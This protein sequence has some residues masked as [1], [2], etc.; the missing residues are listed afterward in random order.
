MQFW[1]R[2]MCFALLYNNAYAYIRRDGMG[3]PV[4]LIPLLPDRTCKEWHH[5]TRQWVYTTEITHSET[6]YDLRTLFPSQ[7][8]HLQGPSID[9]WD[10]D[11]RRGEFLFYAREALG[12]AI[13]QRH[14]KAHYFRRGGRV[15]GILTLPHG[16]SKKAADSLEEGFRRTYESVENSFKTFVA[17]DGVGFEATQMTPEES[18]MSQADAD[19]GREVA[20]WFNLAPSR[21]GVPDSQS[22]G[23][24]AED[25]RAYYEQTLQPWTE[26][27]IR[28]ELEVKLLGRSFADGRHYCKYDTWQLLRG[29]PSDRMDFY[30]KELRRVSC[31]PMSAGP[32]KAGDRMRAATD[33]RTPTPP[34]AVPTW[35]RCVNCSRRPSAAAWLLWV[36]GPR[37]RPRLARWVTTVSRS[38]QNSS[39]DQRRRRQRS[40]AWSTIL[41][42]GRHSSTGSC[43][44]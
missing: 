33:T 43:C 32:W 21:L 34:A 7:V 44:K 39:S 17:R 9:R 41:P 6:A 42:T 16:I 12:L 27:V 15:G 14:Y 35:T 40:R 11:Q 24:K 2:M 13:A 37:R 26:T 38:C 22:Y 10:G 30:R 20:R 1:R 23:S 4:E 25:N 28:P 18:Q 19:L 29:N 8:L 36:T 3:N 31:P 5:D